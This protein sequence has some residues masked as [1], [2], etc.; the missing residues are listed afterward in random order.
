[1]PG[2]KYSLALLSV[3]LHDKAPNKLAF[4]GYRNDYWKDG[5]RVI[6]ENMALDH[7]PPGE[8]CTTIGTKGPKAAV[9]WQPGAC[10]VGLQKTAAF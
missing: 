1:M 5:S 8:E 9:K 2:P 4:I 10:S 7:R 3:F 6:Y